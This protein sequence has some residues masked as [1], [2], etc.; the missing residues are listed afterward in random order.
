VAPSID[1]SRGTYHLKTAAAPERTPAGVTLTLV[2]ERADGIER[3]A[4]RCAM[5]ADLAP[6]ADPDTIVAR[7]VPWIERQFET[8]REAALKTIR[9][10]HRMYEIAFDAANRGPF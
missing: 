9:S 8:L 4:F 2:L 1:T 3:V 7:L 5:R 10:E 6:G